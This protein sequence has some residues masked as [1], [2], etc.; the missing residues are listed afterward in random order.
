M[1]RKAGSARCRH[2]GASLKWDCPVCRRTHWVDEPRCDCGF[3]PGAARAPGAALRGG[4]ARL[5]GPRP[6]RRASTWS[7]SRSSPPTTP[8]RATGSPRSGSTRPMSSI[9]QDG[10]RAAVAGKKLV[11]ARDGGRGLEQTGRPGDARAPGRLDRRGRRPAAGRGAGGPRPQAR[12]DRSAGG[13]GP[14]SPEPGDRRRPA[15]ALAGLDATPPDAP[16]ALDVQVLGD[17]IRLSW[18]P[19]RPTAGAR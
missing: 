6:G 9:A 2:C 12:A 14:L 7:G 10:L 16:T 15:R 18:T 13:A 17:R 11:S 4:P 1:R 19:P 5:P 8:A 3:P